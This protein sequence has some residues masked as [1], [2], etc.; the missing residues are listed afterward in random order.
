MKKKLLIIEVYNMGYVS[1]GK[2]ELYES[3]YSTKVYV[4]NMYVSDIYEILGG[5][6]ARY[7]AVG[8][9]YRSFLEYLWYLC[10]HLCI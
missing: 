10:L 9:G 7:R 8:R 4:K 1:S 3:I 5:E 2:G 6:Y